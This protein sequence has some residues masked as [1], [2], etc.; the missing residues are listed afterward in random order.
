MFDQCSYFPISNELRRQCW[1]WDGI[2]G[3]CL[4][5][6]DSV[7]Q[8]P[9]SVPI[10]VATTCGNMQCMPRRW[11]RVGRDYFQTVS[12]IFWNITKYRSE[13]FYYWFKNNLGMLS[14]SCEMSRTFYIK[15][16]NILDGSKTILEGT[17]TNPSKWPFNHTRFYFLTFI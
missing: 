3:G 14:I 6:P 2:F 12:I 15:F 9:S 11:K 5:P 17:I 8:T 7:L 1:L 4:R 13:I 16:W 10:V